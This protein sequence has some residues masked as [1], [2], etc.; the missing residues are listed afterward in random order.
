MAGRPLS[1]SSLDRSRLPAAYS[2]CHGDA[3]SIHSVE[4]GRREVLRFGLGG[5]L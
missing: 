3:M 5:G 1:V 2:T 4:D